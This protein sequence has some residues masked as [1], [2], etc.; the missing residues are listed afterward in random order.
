MTNTQNT[1]SEEYNVCQG[2]PIASA[3]T[4][5]EEETGLEYREGCPTTPEG[6]A[7]R[8]RQK[9]CPYTDRGVDKKAVEK[10]KKRIGQ[11]KQK[12]KREVK[13]HG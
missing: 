3:H 6:Q 7:M 9:Y 12:R 1:E 5:I 13:A 11:Q 10:E 4:L 8:Q 2:C